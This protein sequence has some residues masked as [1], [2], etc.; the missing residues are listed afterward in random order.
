MKYV[1]VVLFVTLYAFI[2]LF[3]MVFCQIVLG[4][5][6][7]GAGRGMLEILMEAQSVGSLP[8][9][10]FT[11]DNELIIEAANAATQLINDFVARNTGLIF[12]ISALLSLLVYIQIFRSR[13]MELF[14]AIRMAGAPLGT[15]IRYG[16]FAGASANFIIS[17][18]VLLLQHFN[19]FSEAFAQ[20]DAHM[21]NTYG[22]GSI[23]VTLLGIGLITP[24]VEEIIFR[25]MVMFDLGRLF[26]PIAVILI[27]GAIFGLF[28]MVPV[29]IVYTIPLGVYFGYIA[30]KSGSVW[31]AAA[32]HIAMNAVSILL[33]APGMTNL[34]NEPLFS[35]FFMLFSIYMFVSA[36]IYFIKKSPAGT[37]APDL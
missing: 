12:S 32:G 31:P 17:A 30:Y 8:S 10:G 15:D 7:G 13:N 36:L 6:I 20:H 18:A 21:E 3:F 16:A 23:F 2:Y 25:G 5:T 1:K 33:T 19:L 11:V 24:V 29:Q 37:S 26:P 4:L 28:H 9:G 27:Q 14:S 34:L 35:L 22:T